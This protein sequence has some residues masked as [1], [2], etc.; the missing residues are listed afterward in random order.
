MERGRPT[1]FTEELATAICEKLALGQSLLSICAPDEMPAE[2]T[3]RSWA[4]KD[5]AF[6]ARYARAR[7]LGLDAIADEVMAIAD[8]ASADRVTRVNEK[9]K[10]YETVDQEHIA[11]SRLR[12]D[13][14]RWY[15]SKLAPKK[16]GDAMQLKHSDPNGEPLKIEVVRVGRPA[17]RGE[18]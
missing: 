7:D 15:L 3:V 17:K 4:L 14:R 9:G 18:S 6:S 11:R 5:E 1:I 13:A 10:E 16:Y 8:D 2:S 12:F